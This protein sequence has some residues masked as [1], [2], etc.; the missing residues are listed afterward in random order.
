MFVWNEVNPSRVSFYNSIKLNISKG[1]I[2]SSVDLGDWGKGKLIFPK[3]V[4]R[5]SGVSFEGFRIDRT[6]SENKG[7]PILI[8]DD[9]GLRLW[10]M[11]KGTPVEDLFVV[12]YMEVDT[13]SS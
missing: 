12:C 1:L 13:V 4:K 10:K 7:L 11:I 2:R 5:N 6:F 9:E 3:T 8:N